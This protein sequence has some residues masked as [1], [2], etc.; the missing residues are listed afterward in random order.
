MQS[1]QIRPLTGTFTATIANAGTVS[2][3]IEV[4][5][6]AC[7]FFAIPA[8]FTGIAITFQISSARDG[9]FVDAYNAANTAISITVAVSRAYPIPPQVMAAHSF[10]LVSGTSEGAARSIVCSFKSV[11]VAN[12]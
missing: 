11:G 7:G 1:Q 8:A 6:F 9:T 3:V 2:D 4:G 12:P 5:D 10:K